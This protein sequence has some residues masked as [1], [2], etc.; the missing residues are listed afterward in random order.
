VNLQDAFGFF[1]SYLSG[2]MLACGVQLPPFLA[3][4]DYLGPLRWR[5]REHGCGVAANRPACAAA[6][7]C[8]LADLTSAQTKNG[9]SNA[10]TVIVSYREPPTLFW[11]TGGSVAL[12]LSRIA[13][14]SG[15]RRE[16]CCSGNARDPGPSPGPASDL[17][18]GL[19]PL[20][21][22]DQH[23]PPDDTDRV[24]AVRDLGGKMGVARGADGCSKNKGRPVNGVLARI[25]HIR[26]LTA[27]LVL[28]K[29]SV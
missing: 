18:R 6:R 10:D 2:T 21:F 17:T 19:P 24:L 14:P 3:K 5:R 11:F 27:S 28:R 12:L 25:F 7:R 26:K 4:P 22:L 8:D 20:R 1:Q 23:L 16:G 29:L 13:L 15:P 9:P